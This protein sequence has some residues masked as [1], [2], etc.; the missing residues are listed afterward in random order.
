M[1]VVVGVDDGA[2]FTAP[3]GLGQHVQQSRSS[4]GR[5]AAENFYNAAARHTVGKHRE[6]G[7]EQRAPIW[8]VL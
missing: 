1:K 4:S 6:S 7:D 8:A 3:S 2:D 5:T